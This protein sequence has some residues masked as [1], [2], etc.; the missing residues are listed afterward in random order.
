MSDPEYG[1]KLFADASEFG[2]VT[3]LQLSIGDELVVVEDGK[4]VL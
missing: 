3:S 4:F 2:D 1:G